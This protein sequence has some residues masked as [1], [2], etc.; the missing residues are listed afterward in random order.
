MKSP[1]FDDLEDEGLSDIHLL[2]TYV[3]FA[4]RRFKWSIPAIR[5][6]NDRDFFACVR[7]EEKRL[8]EEKKEYDKQ[9]KNSKGH[10]G[11]S[12]PSA[13]NRSNY[14]PVDLGDDSAP[15]EDENML[16]LF[17]RLRGDDS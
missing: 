6:T 16:D 14:K 13:G 11:G 17:N 4:V 3:H 7:I 12:M 1:H 8:E 2:D 15:A 9:M 10:T 5:D